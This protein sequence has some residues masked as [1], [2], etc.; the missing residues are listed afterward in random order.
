MGRPSPFSLMA[1]PLLPG[2]LRAPRAPRLSPSPVLPGELSWPVL[3]FSSLEEAEAFALMLEKNLRLLEERASPSRLREDALELE[4]EASSFLSAL[5]RERCLAHIAP[6]IRTQAK[7]LRERA[8]ELRTI[9]D[10]REALQAQLEESLEELEVLIA[11]L[12]WP[13]LAR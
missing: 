12:R 3:S 7:Q 13:L 4:E 10:R 5:E 6:D 1:S 8:L 2:E 9:A 11:E